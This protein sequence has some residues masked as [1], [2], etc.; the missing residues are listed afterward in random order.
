MSL[1]RSER[2]S[3]YNITM[4]DENAYEILNAFGEQGI[5]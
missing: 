5:G 3:Y 2:M 4:T 1:F